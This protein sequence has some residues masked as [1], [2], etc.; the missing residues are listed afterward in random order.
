MLQW[1]LTNA[2]PALDE[3]LSFCFGDS[4]TYDGIKSLRMVSNIEHNLVIL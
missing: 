1:V 4:S 2:H 3:L